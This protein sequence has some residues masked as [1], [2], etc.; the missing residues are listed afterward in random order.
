M[1]TAAQGILGRKFSDMTPVARTGGIDIMY[2]ASKAAPFDNLQEMVTYAKANPNAV[3]VGVYLTAHSHLTALSVMD[4]L[5][6]DLK[7][8]NIPGGG[9]PIRAALIG[10]QID[11]GI[12]LPA[13]ARPYV[14]KGDMKPLVFFADYKPR[15]MPNLQTAREAGYP[16]LLF[17]VT[18]YWWMHKDAPAEAA[19]FWADKLEQVMKDPELR[20]EMGK[21]I[22][23]LR[24]SRGADLAKEVAE[25]YSNYDKIVEKY[26]LRKK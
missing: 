21:K 3:K 1:G 4:K 15:S 2:V 19:E 25:Q 14:E 16:D 8:I 10:G 23:D 13:V 22:E 7:P 12:S 24:F 5:G 17:N 9:G 18:N 26:G 11:L 20:A 6:I